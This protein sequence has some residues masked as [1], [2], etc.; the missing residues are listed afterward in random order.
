MR[1]RMISVM[2]FFLCTILPLLNA[3]A[4]VVR[5][6]SRKDNT[7]LPSLTVNLQK[8][9]MATTP[10]EPSGSDLKLIHPATLLS[11]ARLPQGF[12][13]DGMN[14][15]YLSQLSTGSDNLRLTKISWQ[16]DGTYQSTYMTLKHFGHGTNLDCIRINGKTWLWTGCDSKGGNSSAITCFTFKSGKVLNR[17]GSC[18]YRI[19][20]SRTGHR[21]AS[22]VYPAIDPAGKRLAVRYTRGN[23]QYFIF[24]KLIKGKEIK[25]RKILR[26]VSCRK[27][28]GPFQGFDIVGSRIY[29]IEGT[30]SR[31][32]M[33][34]LSKKYYPTVIRRYDYQSK[35][36]SGITVTGASKLSHREAEGI[37]VRSN[38]SILIN[39]ASHYK[40]LYTC[41]NI[42]QLTM[43]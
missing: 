8:K 9:I 2:I 31:S 38:G 34:E 11:T 18:S 27:T 16:K 10:E 39:L 32:E 35:K 13:Y 29:T 4:Y 20:L 14:Y 24:Y 1:K 23:K 33:K 12:A 36:T 25:P 17:H 3:N 28:S 6:I 22:N 41:M 19:P 21:Y 7:N 5:Q 30:A 40:K 15:Y 42:Y 26:K 43:D 37:Q